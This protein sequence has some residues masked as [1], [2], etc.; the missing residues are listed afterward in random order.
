[1]FLPVT[2]QMIVSISEVVCVPQIV[3]I[4]DIIS[5]P[6]VVCVPKIV[7]IPELRSVV[8][9]VPYTC[10]S[11]ISAIREWRDTIALGDSCYRVWAGTRQR[12]SIRIHRPPVPV[13]CWWTHA[14]RRM[15]LA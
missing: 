2:P 12:T 14:K 9:L 8:S 11:W 1:M 15:A 5:I 7:S 13:G 4:S 3:S 10:D 6:Q